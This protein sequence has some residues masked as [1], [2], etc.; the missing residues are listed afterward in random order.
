MP[1]NFRSPRCWKEAA[2]RRA[3]RSPPSGGRTARR[4]SRSPATE[5]YFEEACDA[6]ITRY[7]APADADDRRS[8][9]GAA[10]AVADAQARDQ[11]VEVPLVDARDQPIARL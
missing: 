7:P 4:H 9:T 10:Q 6:A 5:R 11:H 2:G 8:P 1:R 3:A